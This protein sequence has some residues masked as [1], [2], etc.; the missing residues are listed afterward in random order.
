LLSRITSLHTSYGKYNKIL[1]DELQDS[2]NNVA[3][4]LKR[5]AALLEEIIRDDTKFIEKIIQENGL[6]LLTR[7]FH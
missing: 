1:P 7:P 3:V 6:R 2:A 5:N 4:E